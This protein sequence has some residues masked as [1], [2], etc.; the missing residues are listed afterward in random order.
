MK[1]TPEQLAQK[2]A[3]A[4]RGFYEQEAAERPEN[5]RTLDEMIQIKEGEEKDDVA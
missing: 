4:D 3:D 2:I 1:L 5:I